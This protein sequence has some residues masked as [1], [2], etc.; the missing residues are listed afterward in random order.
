MS[1]DTH[2][3]LRISSPSDLIALNTAGAVPYAS[4]L[5]S[6][7]MLG[8][9]DTHIAQHP[10]YIIS[11]G[12]AGHR[13]GWGAYVLGRHPQVILWYNS[14]GA[15][16]PF[17][18]GDHQLA[19]SPLFRFFY[20]LRT[21]DLPGGGDGRPIARFLG[22][23]SGAPAGDRA[24]ARDLGVTAT[25]R[26]S[27]VAHTLLYEGPTTLLYFES[28]ARD[29]P[30]WP[31]AEQHGNDVSAFVDAVAAE[32]AHTPQPP[33]VPGPTLDAVR[34]L[35]ENARSAAI[36]GRYAEARA[37]L[38]DAA[39]QN[40]RVGS[41]LVYQYIANVAVLTGDLFTALA[42]QKEALRL[43]PDNPLYRRNL[44][45]LLTV[46]YSEGSRPRAPH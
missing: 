19:E 46:P 35:C 34:A 31:L 24:T 8:L 18:L 12:W 42:A 4:G 39:R 17:Y 36:E 10:V 1:A 7:D 28:D 32:W 43:Q 40:A 21:A 22:S 30:L 41:P 6:I 2:A 9:T 44:V 38:S 11:P 25:V 15:R 26:A 37:M 29:A 14:A 5:P 23:P 33:P 45:G 16:E 20:R 3:T 13:K 27:P